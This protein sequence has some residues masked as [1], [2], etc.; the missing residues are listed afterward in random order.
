MV[1]SKQSNDGRLHLMYIY[2]SGIALC[3]LLKAI[4]KFLVNVILSIDCRLILPFSSKLY[5]LFS[6][7]LD[8]LHL[9]TAG[10]AI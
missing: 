9:Q 2:V 5:S 1:K 4:A 3:L 7:L 8:R 10:N 6:L